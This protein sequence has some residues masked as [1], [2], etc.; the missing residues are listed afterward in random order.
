MIPI[1]EF[2]A[3]LAAV[4]LCMADISGIITDTGTTLM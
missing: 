1:K 4:S 3:G 2:L